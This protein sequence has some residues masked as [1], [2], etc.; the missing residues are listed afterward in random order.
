MLYEY[1]SES[2]DN[3]VNSQAHYK[4]RFDEKKKVT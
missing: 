3:L 4:A 1:Y 2:P